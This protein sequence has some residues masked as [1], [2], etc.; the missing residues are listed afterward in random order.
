MSQALSSQRSWIA[1]IAV[2]AMVASLMAFGAAPAGAAIDTSDSCPASIP[3]AGFTDLAGVPAAAVDAIN[4]IADYGISTGTT[5]TTF[6]PFADVQRWQMALFLTRQAEIH[7]VTLPDGS[8][9]GFVDILA[10]LPATAVKAINQTAQ[11]GLSTGTTATTFDPFAPVERWQMAL[12]LTRLIT[13]AGLT[14]P[15]GADQGFVDILA[16]LPATAVKAINQLGELDIADGTTATTFD[17]FG[18]VERWA[19]A[20]F[21]TRVLAADGI[22]P[23][24]AAGSLSGTVVDFNV[25]VDIDVENSAGTVTTITY[26]ETSD[27]YSIGGTAATIGAFNA[28]LSIGDT[29]VATKTDTD[30]DYDTYALTNVTVTSG[31]VG[32]VDIT[33]NVFSIVTVGNNVLATFGPLSSTETAYSVGGASATYAQFE[34]AVSHGDTVVVTPDGTDADTAID[35]I[36]LTNGTATGIAANVVKTGN[37]TVD[38]G[39][40]AVFTLGKLGDV[41]DNALVTAGDDTTFVATGDPAFTQTYTVDGAPVVFSAFNTALTNGDEVAYSRAAGT[42]TFALTN[43]TVDA[44]FS[45]ITVLDTINGNTLSLPVRFHDFDLRH[46]DRH[47]HHGR[48]RSGGGGRRRGTDRGQGPADR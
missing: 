12:F 3:D 19:M 28:A 32:A 2:L 18:A 10:G 36:A 27:T 31:L 1:R 34:A 47:D 8:D 46:H 11:L 29:I 41:Y 20:L 37:V 30:S 13:A 23:A 35:A 4:C 6:D 44:S 24:P 22:T 7:G 21:L 39:L 33:G 40:D 15:D 5:A 25:G 42:E 43:K 45:G 38:A 16:G 48:R 26:G 9:Q 14:L 17:P